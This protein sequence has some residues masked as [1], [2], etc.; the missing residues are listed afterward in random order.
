M[1][2]AYVYILASGRNGTLYTG[3][4]SDIIKRVYE[5]KQHLVD[6]FTKRYDVTNL[7]WFE[8]YDNMTDAISREKQMKEW[9]RNWKLAT[10]EAVNPSWEDLYTS[11]L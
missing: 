1:K 3:V 10:I 8:R 5:H 4:T 11:L 2:S 7:V 6:G 9:K